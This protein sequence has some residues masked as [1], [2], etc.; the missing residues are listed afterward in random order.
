MVTR[1]L[2]MKGVTSKYLLRIFSFTI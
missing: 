2:H 1:S